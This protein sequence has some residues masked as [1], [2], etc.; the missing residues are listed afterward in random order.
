MDEIVRSY[1]QGMERLYLSLYGSKAIPS[2]SPPIVILYHIDRIY[3]GVAK[4]IQGTIV[5]VLR[6]ATPMSRKFADEI[7]KTIKGSVKIEVDSSIP[8]MTNPRVQGNLIGNTLH[9]LDRD[10]FDI[11]NRSMGIE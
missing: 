10:G 5:D 4:S 7:Y 9:P 3:G 8:L 11:V 6:V 2:Q 1:A